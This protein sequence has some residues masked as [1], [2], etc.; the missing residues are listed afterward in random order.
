MKERMPFAL[1]YLL[2]GALLGLGSPLGLAAAHFFRSLH[3]AIAEWLRLEAAALKW[4]Y[5]YIGTG[6]VIVF[7]IFGYLLGKR[8]DLL[9]QHSRSVESL[10]QSL[11][12]SSITDGITRLYVHSYL[13]KRL[14]EEHVRARRYN[15]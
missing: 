11:E 2:I 8:E 13:M 14:D 12:Q 7:A 1:R 4:V 10:A 9:L 6:S 15:Y 3:P 5:V